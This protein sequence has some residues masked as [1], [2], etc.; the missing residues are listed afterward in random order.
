MAIFL[1]FFTDNDHTVL[2]ARDFHWDILGSGLH[3]LL[4]FD[5]AL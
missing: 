4:V 3:L 1:K 2:I 5:H